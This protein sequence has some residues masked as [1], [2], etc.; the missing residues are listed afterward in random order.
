MVRRMPVKHKKQYI[1]KG[2]SKGFRGGLTNPANWVAAGQLAYRAGRALYDRYQQYRSTN[3]GLK[4]KSG[5]N[6]MTKTKTKTKASK[7]QFD[8]SNS[9]YSYSR[10]N[11]L[12]S[13]VI[14]K[15]SPINIM[16]GSYPGRTQA[17]SGLQGGSTFWLF[18]SVPL[19]TMF[20]Y[21][22]IS[23]NN[24][25]KIFLDGAYACIEY[26]NASAAPPRS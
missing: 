24:T 11:T 4:S 2:T 16:E 9:V 14:T 20:S 15:L 5:S 13:K 26:A 25:K 10:P 19:S 3:A 17:T 7:S 6:T 22:N 8:K 12:V 1:K 21:V 18:D 23:S